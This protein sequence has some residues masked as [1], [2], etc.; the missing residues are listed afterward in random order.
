MRVLALDVGER[1]I[2]VAMSD[3][4]GITAQRLPMLNRRGDRRDHEAVASLVQQHGVTTVV[5]GL[6]LTMR[7]EQGP[8]AKKVLEFVQDLRRQLTV[9]IQLVDE[10]LT[11]V[12]GA[13]ALAEAGTSSRKRKQTIDG[14]A[15]QLILQQFLD[16]QGRP[17]D[18]DEEASSQ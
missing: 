1:R 4:L 6:P 13:R 17:R 8:Q 15:A 14:V 16:M 10:R 5:V 7:G 18:R 12:Q 9:P 11:T 3:S 2:G